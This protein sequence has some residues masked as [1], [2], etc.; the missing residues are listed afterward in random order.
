MA[1]LLWT[2]HPDW[3]EHVKAEL[4]ARIR[5]FSSSF[6]L[7]PADGEVFDNADVYQERL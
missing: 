1:T 7:A 5:S 4:E 3:P 6:L 2:A